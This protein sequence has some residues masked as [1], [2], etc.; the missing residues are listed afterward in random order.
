MNTAKIKEITLENFKKYGTF[1]DMINP[2]ACK[3]GEEPVE[4]Y[5]DMLQLSFGQSNTGSFSICRVLERPLI[6]DTIE[7]HTLAGEGTLPLD[8]D[9]LLSVAPATA[10][11]DVPDDRMEVFH[12]PKGTM[13]TIYPGVWH[14][15][16]FT[17]KTDCVNVLIVLPER[18]Y[19]NDC[20][21]VKLS[22]EKQLKIES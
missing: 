15:A 21:V 6:V 4:F 14:S 10:N 8:G 3:I 9:I 1:A 13:V 19:A 22:G 12:V 11:G 17:Y 5:R 18:V 20:S 2:A 7:F 16:P